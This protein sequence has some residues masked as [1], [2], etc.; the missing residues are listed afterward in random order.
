MKNK[1]ISITTACTVLCAGAIGIALYANTFGSDTSTTAQVTA[2]SQDS[3]IYETFPTEAIAE[4]ETKVRAL[5]KTVEPR[6]ATKDDIYH[7]MLNTID[8]FDKAS[9]TFYF[10][11]GIDMNV[12]VT[13]DFQTELSTGSAYYHSYER[14]IDNNSSERFANISSDMSSDMIYS[15]KLKDEEFYCGNGNAVIMNKSER[16]YKPCPNDIITLDQIG[17]VPDNERVTIAEDGEPCYT[18]R[19]DPTNVEFSSMCL[20]PQE[21]TFGFLT[22]QDLWEIEGTEEINGRLCYHITGQTEEEYGN[23]LNVKTFEFFTDV[24]TG[25]LLKYVGY[26]VNGEISDYMYTENMSFE[27]KAE[28]V[29]VYSDN[30]VM[31][32][33][34]DEKLH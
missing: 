28:D 29:Q 17:E 21:M 34:E 25:V 11:A 15:E 4:T 23:K 12:I 7:M 2:I 5:A 26:D 24:K 19:N 14:Y 9:G 6:E 13:V 33:K 22:N 20:R 31:G 27:D 10:P 1:I 30:L 16:S 8:Y 18:Y 3:N 32:Y